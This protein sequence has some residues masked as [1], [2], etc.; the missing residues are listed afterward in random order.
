MKYRDLKI[1]SAVFI[2]NDYFVAVLVIRIF[3]KAQQFYVA[4]L[5]AVVKNL[6]K[7]NFCYSSY[8]YQL[9]HKNFLICML[10]T[11]CYKV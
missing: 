2:V 11:D 5:Q 3:I 1:T 6:S 7:C 10:S 9:L 4:L 8:L